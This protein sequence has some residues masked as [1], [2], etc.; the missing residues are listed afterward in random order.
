MNRNWSPKN[1]NRA[2]QR[3]RG[4]ERQQLGRETFIDQITVREGESLGPIS[5]T[6]RDPSS[7]QP[8]IQQSLPH[9][10]LSRDFVSEEFETKQ[11]LE[12]NLEHIEDQ[13]SIV[14]PI[15]EYQLFGKQVT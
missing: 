7:Q 13:D 8:R 1:T 6:R 4:R 9:L 11:T 12:N 5:M 3:S 14:Q 2:G 15:I 10:E